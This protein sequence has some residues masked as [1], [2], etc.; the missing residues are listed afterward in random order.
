[1]LNKIL[2]LCMGSHKFVPRSP[3]HISCTTTCHITFTYVSLSVHDISDH[4]WSD[5]ATDYQQTQSQE[6]LY[7]CIWGKAPRLLSGGILKHA[8]HI[9]GKH[10]KYISP[11]HAYIYTFLPITLQLNFLHKNLICKAKH[12]PQPMYWIFMNT[13]KHADRQVC[14]YM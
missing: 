14:R 11:K 5:L 10:C 2:A 8:L 6:H 3:Q 13:D 7:L 9:N 1:M 4:L 12:A